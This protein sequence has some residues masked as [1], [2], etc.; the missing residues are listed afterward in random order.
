MTERLYYDDAYTTEFTARIVERTRFEGRPAVVLDRTFFYPEGGGQPCDRGFIEGIPVVEV[1]TREHDHAVLHVLEQDVAGEQV[2]CRIDQE[3]RF[4]HMQHHTGQHILTQAFVEVAGAHTVGFHL[5]VESVTIDLDVPGLPQEL[6]DRAEELAN[7]IVFENRPVRAYLIDPDE[8]GDVRMRRMPGT[9]L[10]DGLR[11]V[12]VEGFDR[13]AC[14]GTHVA[15][16]GEIGIIKVL[17][18]EKRGAETRVEF[19]CG[20]RALHDY[21]AKNA[22]VGRLTAELTTGQDELL[23][24]VARLREELRST[25]QALRATRKHLIAYEAA[26]LRAAAPEHNGTRIV[27]AVFTAR[28]VEEVRA[29]ASHL[30]QQPATV[31]LLGIA[32]EK[33]QVITARSKDLPF[34]VNT[35]L[36]R[37]LHVLGSERGGGRPDFA[38]GGGIKAPT[39][40]IE[41]A[42]E[43]AGKALFEEET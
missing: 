41:A 7:R 5:G 31:A 3:R 19:R 22:L 39:E 21:R 20:G 29:L 6:V 9:L 26:E 8:A 42:L 12:E 36:R 25:R 24:A 16:T 32:G 34:D 28:P 37:A 2:A 11:V 14:G 40:R 1:H 38:Q 15:R 23:Q 27:R 43:E 18:L 17:R 30:I 33:A 4:D 35:L 13:T 10:T